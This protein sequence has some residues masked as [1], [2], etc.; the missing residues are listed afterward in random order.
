MPSHPDRVR[1]QYD[2]DR[3]FPLEVPESELELDELPPD[4]R[5]QALDDD[6]EGED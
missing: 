1:R 6:M 4:E 3:T 5:E 2:P